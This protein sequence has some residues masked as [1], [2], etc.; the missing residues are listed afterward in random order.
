MAAILKKGT[1]VWGEFSIFFCLLVLEQFFEANPADYR[2][3]DISKIERDR[4]DFMTEIATNCIL[5]A[6][7][8]R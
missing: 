3:F 5:H 6:Y 7:W 2:N 8:V 1:T 4:D